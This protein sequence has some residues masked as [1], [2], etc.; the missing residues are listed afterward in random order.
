[1]PKKAEHKNA[2]D[3]IIFF[4][5]WLI[6]GGDRV[7]NLTRWAVDEIA[8]IERRHRARRAVD[9]ETHEELVGT[10]VAN[11][12]RATL[13]EPERPL[14][15]TVRSNNR[16]AGYKRPALRLLSPTISN[17]WDAG[18]LVHHAARKPGH[19]G[20]LEPSP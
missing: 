5:Q 6:P 3:R 16:E 12:A 17:A 13:I 14:V 2:E 15:V 20:S 7:A 4:N 10:I 1:M 19:A 8:R 18:L 11:L 9:Q